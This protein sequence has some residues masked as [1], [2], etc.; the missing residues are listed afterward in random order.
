[1]RA[2]FETNASTTL[3][4]SG[5]LQLV[6]GQS[7]PLRGLHLEWFHPLLGAGRGHRPADAGGGLDLAYHHDFGGE[8]GRLVALTLK[9]Q[10]Q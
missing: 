8:G 2:D 3:T 9:L 5:G 6:L 1:M 7:V 10:V 4:Y